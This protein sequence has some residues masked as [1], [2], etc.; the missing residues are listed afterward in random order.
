MHIYLQVLITVS[1]MRK[2]YICFKKIPA[3]TVHLGKPA[4]VG[5]LSITDTEL[6]RAAKKAEVH[7][8]VHAKGITIAC[9]IIKLDNVIS[10]SLLK[11]EHGQLWMFIAFSIYN[12]DMGAAANNST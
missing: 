9:K 3:H 12:K 11:F 4:Q 1:V 7:L 10:R 5:P 8:L 6:S 2:G